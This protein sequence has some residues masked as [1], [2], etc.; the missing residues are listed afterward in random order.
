MET[1]NSAAHSAA[2]IAHSA[3]S[4][5]LACLSCFLS[6]F[7]IEALL[8]ASCVCLHAGMP[9]EGDDQVLAAAKKVQ[10]MGADVVLAKL[11]TKG[12]ML[13]QK[14]EVLQQGIIRADK[15][16]AVAV[17]LH[18]THPLLTTHMRKAPPPPYLL[19]HTIN[20]PDPLAQLIHLPY[21]FTRTIN[22]PDPLA[23]L[24]HLP[25]PLT[26]TIQPIGGQRC[27]CCG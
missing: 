16:R 27:K 2:G 25:Y 20:T 11:G 22:T 5:L 15:V 9:T 10:E 24:I 1:A 23:Q 26:H 21:P 17:D 14:D 12:S 6:N 4:L 3:Y 8:H 7:V 19:T 18:P 13:I